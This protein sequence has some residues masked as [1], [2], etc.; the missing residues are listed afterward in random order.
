MVK[1]PF[2][3]NTSRGEVVEENALLEA[4][5]QG[6]IK[7]A[8]IDVLVGDSAWSEKSPEG[9]AL[10]DFARKND[11]LLISPHMGG[12]GD[13]SIFNTRAFITDKFLKAKT[14]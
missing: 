9:N 14:K 2:F 8:G 3:I 6:Q 12:Y 11:N 13:N 1:K 10:I 7:A 5:K 4:L